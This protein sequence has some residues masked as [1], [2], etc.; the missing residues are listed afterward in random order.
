MIKYI[1]TLCFPLLLVANLT[2]ESNYNK[3]LALL[4]SFDIEPSFLYDPVMNRMKAK[5]LAKNKHFFKAM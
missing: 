5:T 1:L 3:E 4:D 2:Y